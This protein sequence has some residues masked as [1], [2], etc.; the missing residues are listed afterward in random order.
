[1]TVV[2]VVGVD[3]LAAVAESV[4]RRVA[5]KSVSD[6]DVPSG[7]VGA[8]PVCVEVVAADADRA[9]DAVSTETAL[10]T[11][12]IVDVLRVSTEFAC[13]SVDCSEAV[14]VFGVCFATELERA[15]VTGR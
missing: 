4:S 2:A 7:A 12:D 11:A 10:V 13:V 15:V 9:D 1:M 6:S 8:C 3:A 14:G 5:V